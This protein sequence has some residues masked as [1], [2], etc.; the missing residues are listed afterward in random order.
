MIESIDI[1]YNRWVKAFLSINKSSPHEETENNKP[2]YRNFLAGDAINS[3]MLDLKCIKEGCC[4][5]EITIFFP[6][7][8]LFIVP[9]PVEFDL[10]RE[11]IDLENEEFL[12]EHTEK[13]QIH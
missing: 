11:D 4:G 12:Y 7:S 8:G 3:Q 1:T 13:Y 9:I 6:D 10:D 2:V 5:V